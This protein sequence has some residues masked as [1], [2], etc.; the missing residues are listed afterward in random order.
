MTNQEIID[1]LKGLGIRA[2]VCPNCG[3]VK[4]VQDDRIVHHY[5]LNTPVECQ[6]SGVCVLGDVE[7]AFEQIACRLDLEVPRHGTDYLRMAGEEAK[8][9]LEGLFASLERAAEVAA[10]LVPEG[11]PVFTSVTS[12]SGEQFCG[13][14]SCIVRE[15]MILV[16]PYAAQGEVSDIVNY[17][18][19]EASREG[20]N[21]PMRKACQHIADHIAEG[22]YRDTE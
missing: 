12:P 15:V 17:L 3:R 20:L 1:R 13:C 18:M 2:T 22:A 7:Q 16:W 14:V 19:T 9:R 11:T 21:K 8:A 10:T 5:V 4:E 6:G